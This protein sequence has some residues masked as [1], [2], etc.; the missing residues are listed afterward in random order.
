[1][2]WWSRFGWVA[3]FPTVRHV[4]ETPVNAGRGTACAG[5][6]RASVC[7]RHHPPGLAPHE[8]TLCTHSRWG[9]SRHGTHSG[10]YGTGEDFFDADRRACSFPCSH[11]QAA[12]QCIPLGLPKPIAQH[13]RYVT[14]PRRDVTFPASIYC[15][16][17]YFVL[18]YLFFTHFIPA[19]F[20]IVLLLF[21]KHPQIAWR[22]RR[23]EQKNFSKLQVIWGY[24]D[25]YLPK[26]STL[27]V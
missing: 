27:T 3:F 18:F 26:A 9:K 6:C 4:A 5:R 22:G 14:V 24:T 1:M 12:S 2:T 10:R 13:C 21:L 16:L 25:L 19:H 20:L 17:I 7:H 23:Q 8:S 15:L 11:P